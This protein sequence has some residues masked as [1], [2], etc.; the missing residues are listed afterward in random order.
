MATL[1]V[2]APQDELNRF[3]A[4]LGS[5]EFSSAIEIANAATGQQRD[6]LLSRVAG[7]QAIGGARDHAF[8]TAA[9]IENDAARNG[10]LAQMYDQP[11]FQDGTPGFGSG[12][13]GRGQGAAGGITEQDFDELINLIQETIDPDSWEENGGSGRML[14]FPSGVYVDGQGTL[15]KVKQSK[16][17]ALSGIREQALKQLDDP[18]VMSQSRLRK[19]SLTRLERTLQMLAAQSRVPSPDMLHLGGMYQLKYVIFYPETRDVVIAGPAGPWHF[20]ADGRAINTETG[21]PLLYMDDL[22]VC[23]RNAREFGGQFGC[24]IDP[25]QENLA[26]VTRFQE[27]TTLTGAPWRSRLRELLG[28]QDVTVKGIDP[29]THAG[30]VLVE[31]DYRMKLVGLGLESA[32]PGLKNYFDRLHLDEQGNPPSSDVVR[33]WFT[34]NYDAVESNADRTIFEIKGQGVKLLSES[35]FLD[36]QGRR[37]HTGQSSAPTK[38]F[39]DDFTRYFPQMAKKYP[40]YGELKNLFDCALAANLIHNEGLARQIDWQLNYFDGRGG[41]AGLLHPVAAENTPRQVDSVVSEKI[42][43]HRE[44]NRTLKHTVV[45][46]SGGVQYDASEIAASKNVMVVDQPQLAAAR[47]QSLPSHQWRQWWWD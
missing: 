41:E 16:S 33:W 29:A 6:E 25:R 43:R 46:I 47:Q 2:A 7:G 26:A 45:G 34:M 35:E 30:R 17:A 11:N 10:I 23:L 28:Q 4:H 39:A 36:E 1:A 31:A 12:G 20:D 5:G 40:I 15:R 21:I 22:V 32:V 14:A 24:S 27:S 44:G 38:G 8:A 42:M 3:S 13:F 19:I 18:S 9:M 37:V